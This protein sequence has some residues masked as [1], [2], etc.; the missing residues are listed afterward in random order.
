[1]KRSVK[2]V[3]EWSA[4]RTALYI[5]NICAIVL[6]S[7]EWFTG[8]TVPGG[9]LGHVIVLLVCIPLMMTG[10]APV[11]GRPNGLDLLV[12]AYVGI[13]LLSVINVFYLGGSEVSYL[14]GISY[15]VFPIAGYFFASLAAPRSPLA[16]LQDLLKT[17]ATF[18]V[19]IVAFGTVLLFAV[20]DAYLEY[21]RDRLEISG[22]DFNP[23]MLSYTSSPTVTG[24]LS[25][26]LYPVAVYLE[27][28]GVISRPVFGTF[29]LSSLTGLIFSF[30]RSAWV[31]FAFLVLALLPSQTR[32]LK[33][34][35]GFFAIVV[36]ALY[37]FTIMPSRW[38]DE[39]DRRIG[40]VP[41]VLEETV[42]RSD[43][44]LAAVQE[45]PFGE[46]LGQMGHKSTHRA[47]QTEAVYD[48]GYVRILSEIGVHGFALFLALNVIGVVTLLKGAYSDR[49]RRSVSLCIAGTLVV[50]YVQ[51]F[52]SNVFDLHYSA[53]V[54]WTFVGTISFLSKQPAWESG[55]APL[56]RLA[57]SRGG[58]QARSSASIRIYGDRR[59]R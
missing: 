37:A 45:H 36:L 25:A 21:Y 57:L 54:F 2:T 22:L 10:K 20:P 5:L 43:F 14:K 19:V 44:G 17:F 52:G 1:M 23:R 33:H 58:G 12:L 28:A 9:L 59:Y 7:L 42:E 30:A 41:V 29:V 48:Q 31:A 24:T 47:T 4:P 8:E 16:F 51:A 3:G 50:F 49:A 15:S 56:G 26:C 11:D 27:R 18:S 13:N 46:G 40:A 55:A 6:F 53:H 34:A 35:L 39:V 38:R 32:S